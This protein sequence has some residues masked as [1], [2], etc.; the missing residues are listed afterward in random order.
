MVEN[1]FDLTDKKIIVTGSTG[2]LG[3]PLVTYLKS[4]GSTVISVSRSEFQNEISFPLDISDEDACNAFVEQISNRFGSIDGIINNAYSGQAGTLD[5]TTKNDFEH[6]LAMNLTY[7]FFFIKG[8]LSILSNKASIVNIA[9]MYGMVSPD[10]RIYGDSG[11]NNPIYYGAGKAGLIQMTK[12]LA[13]HLA[14]NNIRVNA[15]SPGPFPNFSEAQINSDFHNALNYKVPMGRIGKPEEL[16]GVIQ[17]LLSDAS[18]YITGTNIPVDG[19]W[20]AW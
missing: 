17:F 6:S 4:V 16:W 2:Y 3:K 8:L 18:S 15:V 1:I 11:H 13:C 9:S 12:Y 10:P 20:T 19:G 14:K 7:P 5:K